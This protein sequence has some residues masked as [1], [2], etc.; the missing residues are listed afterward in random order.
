MSETINGKILNLSNE[1]IEE[2]AHAII[3]I[4]KYLPI[5]KEADP[6]LEANAILLVFLEKL[7]F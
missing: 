2:I 5:I 7:I 6:P 1:E 3:E 4:G